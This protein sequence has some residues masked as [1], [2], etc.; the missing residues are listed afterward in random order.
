MK[1]SK[2]NGFPFTVRF[3]IGLAA[4]GLVLY[5]MHLLAHMITNLFLAFM[6][7]IVAAP[8]LEWLRKKGLPNW[9]AFLLTL[10]AVAI[11]IALLVLFLAVATTNLINAIP[12]YSQDLQDVQT[13]FYDKVL[14][15]KQL[16]SMFS[17]LSNRL[18]FARLFQIGGNL[19]GRILDTLGNVFI[20]I[21]YVIFM[22]VQVFT[23]PQIL[24]QE[25]ARGNAHLERI[26]VYIHD[27]RRYLVITAVIALVTGVLDTLLFIILGI[28]NP[29]MW[30]G[31]AA[32]LSFVPSI[33]FWI[34]A[35]PP[36]ILAFFEHGWLIALVTI[37][38]II[39][40]NGFADN[41][42]KPR[43]LGSGLDLSPFIVIF[44]VIFWA[45]ILGPLGA[46]IGVPL[47]MAI[48]SLLFEADESMFW[49]ANLMG[50]G[51]ADG[52]LAE[53]RLETD[54]DES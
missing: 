9:L 3:L 21:L 41:V 37:S 2:E 46:I 10:T 42:I 12:T 45:L 14:N 11:G 49:A 19:L 40:I 20:I 29:F 27:L 25:V 34:A 28:P 23:T 48:K 6:I 24:Q 52:K 32:V 7:A 30:G 47:S 15:Q 36:S 22:L 26:I 35:I 31:I 38:G 17:E 16:D 54:Q 1:T 50:S 53:V 8:L 18:D 33:G 51:P 43:Y 4:A 13:A 39:L 5:F 44:S